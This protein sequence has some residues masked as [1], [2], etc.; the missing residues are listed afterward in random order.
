LILKNHKINKMK[1]SYSITVCNELR[2]IK[3]LICC[4]Q[5][6]I[7]PEDEIVVVYDSTNGIEEVREYLHTLTFPFYEFE[8][9]N[10]FSALKNYLKNVSTG[11]Y[12]FFLDADEIPNPVLLRFLPELLTIN[13]IEAYWI[14]RINIVNSIT[15]EYV[16]QQRWTINEKG[17]INWPHDAQLRIIKNIPEIKWVGQVHEK[18]TGFHTLSRL[19][20][21]EEYSLLHVKE[22]ERQIRQNNLY[23]TISN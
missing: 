16:E 19:P 2:E 11:D 12:V 21:S 13:D 17:W 8:F 6:N 22:F 4:L 9:K 10:D 20:D 3:S 18:L 14:P 7:R 23:E 15:K 5:E 1:I